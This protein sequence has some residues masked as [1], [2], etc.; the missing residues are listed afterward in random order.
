MAVIDRYDEKDGGDVDRIPDWYIKTLSQTIEILIG[1]VQTLTNAVDVHIDSVDTPLVI[2]IDGVDTPTQILIR[3][4]ETWSS[5]V[6]SFK[7][8]NGILLGI[9]EI[10]REIN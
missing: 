3:C 8:P 7:T 9:I 1:G 10:A 5:F 6:H 4:I 2:L